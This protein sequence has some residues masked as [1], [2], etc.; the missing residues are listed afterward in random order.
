MGRDCSGSE[1]DTVKPLILEKLFDEIYEKCSRR[2]KRKY[3]YFYLHGT[4]EE[5]KRSIA[6]YRAASRAYREFKKKGKQ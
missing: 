4:P 2:R 5:N 6:R 3:Y 1:G